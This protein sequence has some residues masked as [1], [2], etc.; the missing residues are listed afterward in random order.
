M[1]KNLMAILMFSCFIAFCDSSSGGFITG[2]FGIGLGE[3]TN[4]NPTRRYII[5][6]TSYKK[7]SMDSDFGIVDVI[8]TENS[9]GNVTSIY[10]KKTIEPEDDVKK[11]ANI[12]ARYI[13]TYEN[14]EEVLVRK[15]TNEGKLCIYLYDRTNGNSGLF[16]LYHNSLEINFSYKGNER[17]GR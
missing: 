13:S 9:E 2:A 15:Y 11:I 1:K 12:I 10:M 16:T 17:A 6:G 3:P 4:E 7:K 14:N 8:W 5:D